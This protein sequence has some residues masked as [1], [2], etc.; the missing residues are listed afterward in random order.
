MIAGRAEWTAGEQ[1]ATQRPGDYILHPANIV[2]AMHTGEEPLLAVYS[3]TGDVVSPSVWAE[4]GVHPSVTVTNEAIP[5]WP[6]IV[7]V[8]GHEE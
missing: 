2:H 1:T 6:Q 5:N 8:C 3:W 4:A 7:R